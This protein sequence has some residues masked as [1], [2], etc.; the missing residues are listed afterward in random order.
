MFEARPTRGRSRGRVWLV[1]DQQ[2]EK[3][4]GYR[5]IFINRTMAS[6]DPFCRQDHHHRETQDLDPSLERREREI[7]PHDRNATIGKKDR[8]PQVAR[9]AVD[10]DFL[11]EIDD[12]GRSSSTI[13]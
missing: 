6:R 11:A 1:F 10:Q 12:S 13:I 2:D 8:Q 9:Q 5:R 7:R 4:L 3:E